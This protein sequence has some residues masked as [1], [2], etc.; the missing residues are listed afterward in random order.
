MITTL[1]LLKL[2]KLQSANILPPNLFLFGINPVS[3]NFARFVLARPRS[4]W[5]CEKRPKVSVQVKGTV[6]N[7]LEYLHE[8]AVP[9]SNRLILSP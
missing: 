4:V 5:E 8:T 6:E 9:S 3:V 1:L 7:P 2:A